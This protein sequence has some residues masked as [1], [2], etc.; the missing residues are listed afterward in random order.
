MITIFFFVTCML[1]LRLIGLLSQYPPFIIYL[2]DL[3]NYISPPENPADSI[4]VRD[5]NQ[6]L[7]DLFT[8][9][10]NT[11]AGGGIAIKTVVN[12][13]VIVA[14]FGLGALFVSTSVVRL[15]SGPSGF[16]PKNSNSLTHTSVVPL[17]PS[18]DVIEA[19]KRKGMDESG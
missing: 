16:G 1:F 6:K 2:A 12:A 8:G 7:S 3:V 17:D 19:C 13:P 18:S 9:I 14:S 15:N 11:G 10:R 5:V 4:T